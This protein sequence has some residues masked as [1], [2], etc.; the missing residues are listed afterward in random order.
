M[1]SS[2]RCV[3]RREHDRRRRS[4]RSRTS[5]ADP[6]PRLADPVRALEEPLPR[7]TTSVYRASFTLV[8]RAANVFFSSDS[9]TSSPVLE[10]R[11]RGARARTRRSV[12]VACGLPRQL[13][14]RLAEEPLLR[15]LLDPQEPANGEVDDRRRHVERVRLLVDQRPDLTGPEVLRRRELDRS[16]PALEERH[17]LHLGLGRSA[18]DLVD[19]RAPEALVPAAPPQQPPEAEDDDGE[20]AGR[21]ADRRRR[22]A[23]RSRRG[24]TARPGSAPARAPPPSGAPRRPSCAS[25]GPRFACANV[26]NRAS[27][28]AARPHANVEPAWPWKHATC[29]DRRPAPHPDAAPARSALLPLG[30]DRVPVQLVVVGEP[31]HRALDAVHDRVGVPPGDRLVRVADPDHEVAVLS[32]TSRRRRASPVAP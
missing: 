7:V 1:P 9:T 5:D 22:R 2:A 14:V 15:D 13:P 3:Q 28:P 19:R 10:Q 16:V 6:R 11:R 17:R 8:S 31:V 23:E 27:E 12:S 4:R 25:N 24:S 21:A 18:H 20:Q 30:A 29:G 32:M 26:A